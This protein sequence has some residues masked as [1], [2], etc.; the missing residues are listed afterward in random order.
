VDCFG[1]R[2]R[3]F[4]NRLAIVDPAGSWTYAQL[5]ADASRL[6]G[7]LLDGA[8]DLAEARVALLCTP[9]RDFVTAL[10]ACW[11]AGGIAVPVHPGHPH[12][13]QAYVVRQ[14]GA[15]LIVSSREYDDDARRLA[16]EVAARSV[17]VDA[18]SA[19]VEPGELDDARRALIIYT[20]GTTGAPKGV[21]HT[22]STLRAQAASLADAWAW[23]ADDRII[24][25][26]PLH[27]VHGLVNVALCALWSGA[28]CE[29]PGNFDARATWDRLAS[30]DLTLFMAVPTI[31]TRLIT[32][33][34]EAAPFDRERWSAGAAHL[35]LMVSGSAAL[36][37]ATLERWRDITGH[38]LLER[39][40]MTE[41]GMALSNS[42]TSRVAGKVGF[43]LPGV[44][45]RIVDD[46]SLDVP[47]GT[48]GELLV[49]GP[50]VFLEYWRDP[51]ATASAFVDG[52]FRTGDV[53]V[54]EPEGY[55]LLGRASVD[56]IKSGGEK[57]SALEVEEALRAH[58]DI[59]D[60]AV[61]GLPDEEWGERVCAAVVL[62]DGASLDSDDLRAWAKSRVAPAKVPARVLFRRELPRNALGKVIKPE[63]VGLFRS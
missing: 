42:L 11:A 49:R 10:L 60:C 36:P 52:W 17:A 61:V 35:R 15:S 1:T 62:R 34:T 40:G 22:H 8:T 44:H 3:S 54:R 63:V 41:L 27:H 2:V 57:V 47:D 48:A 5:D 38:V 28:V 25:V 23:S 51:E 29:A 13:E 45:I 56:I 59:A 58:P 20:S 46:A 43:P 37:V 14:S 53:A 33:W 50:N 18:A 55:R 9:G 7:A 4:G 24:L 21:V 39:Y 31:Y 12:P 30:G 26:L 16:S 32:A 6:A 19:P